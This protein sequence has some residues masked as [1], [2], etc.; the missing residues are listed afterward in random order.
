MAYRGEMHADLMRPSGF[1]TYPDERRWSHRVMEPMQYHDATYRL[2]R[3]AGSY[4]HPLALRRM[5]SERP[6]NLLPVPRYAPAH[7]RHIYL[8]YL[9]LLELAGES[10]PSER[11]PRYDHY[12]RGVLIQPMDDSGTNDAIR[13]HHR[14]EVGKPRHER[15]DERR[16]G[17]AGCGMHRHAGGLIDD[18]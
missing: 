2:A 8:A 14:S 10:S 3:M 18:D 15:V 12:A 5:T 4:R 11:R 17:M 7:Q 9:P 1:G 6:R 16:M 13:F